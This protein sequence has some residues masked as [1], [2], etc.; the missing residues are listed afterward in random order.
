[1]LPTTLA[2]ALLGAVIAPAGAAALCT[3]PQQIRAVAERFIASLAAP[4]TTVHA[5]AG[6]LDDRLTL[7]RCAG[8]LTPSLPAGATVRPR[9]AVAVR[10]P[11]AGGWTIHVPVTVEVDAT[12]LV[13]RR[14]LSRGEV[15]AAVDL[16]PA[17]RR[18]PGLGTQYVSSPAD[19]SGRRLRRPVA[20]GQP[21]PVDALDAPVVVERG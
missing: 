11:D 5:V 19:L 21:V 7:S 3:D 8:E 18:V 12:V 17:T 14:A 13:A 10:C 2:C 6:R 1:M 16:E 4:G 20:T 9:T 15:P